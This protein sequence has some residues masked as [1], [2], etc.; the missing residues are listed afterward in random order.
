MK[1]FPVPTQKT[2]SFNCFR[3]F[4]ADIYIYKLLKSRKKVFDTK[5]FTKLK[6]RNEHGR[7]FHLMSDIFIGFSVPG[8]DEQRSSND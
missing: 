5:A 6:I 4:S 1:I 8:F 2:I 3:D 7:I